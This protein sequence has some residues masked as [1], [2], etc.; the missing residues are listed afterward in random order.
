[1]GTKKYNFVVVD[2]SPNTAIVLNFLLQGDGVEG[3]VIYFENPNEALVF[4]QDHSCDLLFLDVEMPEMS[5]FE[6]LSQLIDPPLTIILTSYPGK[7]AEQAFQFLNKK[8]IDFISKDQLI[9][10][11]PRIKERFLENYVDKF[12]YVKS[13]NNLNSIVRIPA[14][15]IIYFIK[16]RNIVDVVL[17][18]ATKENYYLE[19]TL[20]NLENMLPKD[21]FYRIRKSN[22]IMLSHLKCYISGKISMGLDPEGN[23]IVIKVPHRERRNFIDYFHKRHSM[24]ILKE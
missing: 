18:G 1:M 17:S 20:E 16:N 10:L 3:E 14:A 22:L 24:T 6:F 21:T 19:T 15:A 9:P 11:F 13:K 5:G 2:D 7:Y 4:F 8:L 23:E 12:L